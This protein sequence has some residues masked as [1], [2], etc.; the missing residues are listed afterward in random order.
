MLRIAGIVLSIASACAASVPARFALRGAVV[1][2]NGVLAEGVIVVSGNKIESVGSSPAPGGVRVFETGATICP[3][4]IDL[5]NHLT[6]NVFPRWN[7][8]RTFTNRYQW[9]QTPE[10]LMALSEPQSLLVERGLGPA[11]A[12][13]GEIKAI[14]NG[15]T[16]LAGLSAWD[17][18]PSFKPPYAGLMRILDTGSQLTPAGG[19]EPVRYEVFPLTLYE[20]EASTIRS[21]LQGHQ[22]HCLVIHLGEGNPTDAS[23]A[24]EYKILKARGLLM[25]GV[26]LVHG[27]ALGKAQFDEMARLGV[28]LVWSP[29]SNFELYG[30][31][32]DV[33][34]A[35]AA[36]VQIALAPDWS[37][38]GSD[39][40]LDEL[41]YAAIW[42]ASLQ[43]PVFT[44]A[45]LVDMA[46]RVPS[47][48]VG[49]DDAIGALT[50]GLF[51][52]LLVVR[53]GREGDTFHDLT[54]SGPR[55][56][57]MVMVGGHPIMGRR[58]L[59]EAIDPN[60]NWQSV[61]V[62][63]SDKQ[64]ALPL[65]SDFPNWTALHETLERE[66]ESA[67]S[68]LGPLSAD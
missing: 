3:G 26:I 67:G 21:Q 56:V 10:Y 9:Q 41:K 6:W 22:L 55:D 32:T 50:P 18:G 42:N 51:A 66:L 15:A 34:A 31:T 27:D 54:H 17:L 1:T 23:A 20:S 2:P 28:G 35:K 52:D 8:G 29:R 43:R 45:E 46:T 59:V 39:G 11:M 53:K 68:R 57:E 4:L 37:P 38:T 33:A 47:K 36:G 48:L 16:S 62:G 40:M 13:F 44:D 60:E 7:A 65:S 58:Q 12:R 5:H 19:L 14:A 24:V 25:K 61:R 63:N 30:A 49:E 64:L